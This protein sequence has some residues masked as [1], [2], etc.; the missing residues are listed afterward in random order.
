[1]LRYAFS[2]CL[3]TA[4]IGAALVGLTGCGGIATVPFSA[5]PDSGVDAV[6]SM[7]A[8]PLLDGSSE[9]ACST[10]SDCPDGQECAWTTR[11]DSCSAEGTCVEPLPL[12]GQCPAEP[13][14]VACGCDGVSFTWSPCGLRGGWAPKPS[15]HAGPCVDA[16]DAGGCTNN[17]CRICATNDDCGSGYACMFEIGQGCS[18]TGTCVETSTLPACNCASLPACGCDGETTFISCCSDGYASTP[19][20][21]DGACGD[22][23]P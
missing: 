7:D 22:A 3:L 14:L 6:S 21:H 13:L 16:G 18:A 19:I 5:P 4:F 10:D 23:G 12:Y 8:A 11:S 2:S 17:G 1:M 15:L 20:S 9:I